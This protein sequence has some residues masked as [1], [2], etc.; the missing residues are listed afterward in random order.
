[1]RLKR[2]ALALVI[3]TTALTTVACD[4][5]G[6]NPYYPASAQKPPVKRP[7]APANTPEAKTKATPENTSAENPNPSTPV[8]SVETPVRTTPGPKAGANDYANSQ[9]MAHALDADQLF[10]PQSEIEITRREGTST[11]TEDG[12]Y[13]GSTQISLPATEASKVVLVFSYLGQGGIK[14]K[15]GEETKELKGQGKENRALQAL[16]I[17]PDEDGKLPPV[18]VTPLFESVGA[19]DLS[20]RCHTQE[21][22]KCR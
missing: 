21:T 3:A 4:S 1:M 8:F 15:I 19:W 9:L 22:G 18:I 12:H 2:I 5:T 11:I 20:L 6:S 7:S 17:R 16:N 10:L 13:A 14:I